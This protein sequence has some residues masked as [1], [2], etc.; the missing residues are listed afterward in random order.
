MAPEPPEP[1]QYMK[2]PTRSGVMFGRRSP[3]GSFT[4]RK[5][6]LYRVGFPVRMALGLVLI[7]EEI[8]DEATSAE[9]G[10]AIVV[11]IRPKESAAAPKS[12]ALR[13]LRNRACIMCHVFLVGSLW[14]GGGRSRWR[15]TVERQVPERGSETERF[16]FGP[17]P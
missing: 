3:S 1:V 8:D 7:A 15:A 2:P 11:V 17:V 14:P 9:A 16:Q 4:L 5:A 6:A 12:R 10:L 13:R